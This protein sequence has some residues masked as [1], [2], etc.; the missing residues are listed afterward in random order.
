MIGFHTTSCI[1]WSYCYD[2]KLTR[3]QH[4]PRDCMFQQHFST[5]K[6]KQKKNE[7]E[8]NDTQQQLTDGT[9][10][11]KRGEHKEASCRT[12]EV[13]DYWGEGRGCCGVVVVPQAFCIGKKSL[14]SG[15]SSSSLYNLSLK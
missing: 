9:H 5:T 2:P 7:I 8:V 14:N 10:Y 3:I 11:K 1:Q 13:W 4:L 15:G 12:T 6:N